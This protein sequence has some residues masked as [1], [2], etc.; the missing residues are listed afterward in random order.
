MRN[1]KPERTIMKEKTINSE[2]LYKGRIISLAKD[3]VEVNGR[4]TTRE[5]IT[6]PGSAVIIPVLDTK[7][8]KI[9][10]IK[11]FR[12]AAKTWMIE[13]PAGT[14]KKQ[15]PA[16]KCAMREITEETGYT[17]STMKKVSEFMPSPGMMTEKMSL[18]IAAGL[19]KTKQALDFDEQITLKV[20][21]LGLAIDM[22]F[23]GKIHDAKTIAGILMLEHIYRDEKLFKRYLV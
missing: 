12:Y 22:I 16:L 8:K 10:L 18:F 15:E 19:K 14:R 7:N 9:I 17:A 13:L 23:S 1:V 21:P 20:T 3:I 2:T 6:H 5:L 4:K 11:Q